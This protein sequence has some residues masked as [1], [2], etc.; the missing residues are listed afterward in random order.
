MDWSSFSAI[1][2]IRLVLETLHV[3]TVVVVPGHADEEN[4]GAGAGVCGRR[5]Q[6][7]DT[8][9]LGGESDHAGT[10]RGRA[11]RPPLT[12]GMSAISS[13]SFNS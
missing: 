1:A 6:V 9:R 3:P 2:G 7:V 11:H 5:H 8:D 13:P 10:I 4:G 12:G